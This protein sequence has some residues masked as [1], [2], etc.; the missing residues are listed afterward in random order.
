MTKAEDKDYRDCTIEKVDDGAEAYT[1]KISSGFSIGLKKRHCMRVMP[2]VGASIRIYGAAGT[3]IRGIDINGRECFY[4]TPEEQVAWMKK[5][6]ARMD[7]EMK[8]RYETK[9]KVHLDEKYA[10][11]PELFKRRIDKFRTNNPEF[12][13]KYE[14]YEMFVCTEAIKIATALNDSEKIK[15][16]MDLPYKEQKFLVDISDQHSGNTMGAAIALAFIYVTNPEGVVKL[17]SALAPL[18]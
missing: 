6:A 13:W 11:L 16:F 18:L 7:L 2:H 10:A 9:E 15:C 5:E 4:K 12:R 14:A 3:L 17:H 1:L 8:E